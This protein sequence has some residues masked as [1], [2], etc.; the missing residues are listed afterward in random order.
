MRSQGLTLLGMLANLWVR[1]RHSLLLK[2]KLILLS[3][4]QNPLGV[5]CIFINV[6]LVL[7]T[8]FHT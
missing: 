6:C 3:A 2:S 5:F 7:T 8:V 4:E 1:D